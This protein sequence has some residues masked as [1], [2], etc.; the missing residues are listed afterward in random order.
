MTENVKKAIAL[1]KRDG[2]K[3]EMVGLHEGSTCPIAK[4][5]EGV[6]TKY[7]WDLLSVFSK[8]TLTKHGWTELTYDEFI[9]WY[10]ELVELDDEDDKYIKWERSDEDDEYIK[11]Y[12]ADRHGSF[13]YDPDKHNQLKAALS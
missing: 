3:P 1:L 6:T 12:G 11:W 7:H 9:E 8:S 10:D 4:T 2:C 5:Y 13:E